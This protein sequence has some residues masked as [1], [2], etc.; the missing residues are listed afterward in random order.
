MKK[1]ENPPVRTAQDLERKYKLNILNKTADYVIETRKS[2]M[3]T[4]EEWKSGKKICRG[5]LVCGSESYGSYGSDFMQRQKNAYFPAGFFDKAP[6][7]ILITSL[8]GQTAGFNSIVDLSDSKVSWNSIVRNTGQS[9][10]TV[11][12]MIEAIS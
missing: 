1:H 11:S 7:F 5:L 3:W 10:Y 8:S 6:S 2:G 12:F 9:A 4:L